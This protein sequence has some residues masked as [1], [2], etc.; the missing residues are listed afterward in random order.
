MS[1]SL[2]APIAKDKTFFFA[3]ADY[4]RQDRTTQL[5]NTLP[6]FVLDNGSLEYVGKYR[7]A[8]VDARV[9]H[10]LSPSQ[11][12]MFRGNFDRMFDTNPNDTVIGTTAPT[13][14]RKYTRRG[15]SA[16]AGHTAVVSPT[17][18]NEA[19]FGF[20]NGDPVTLWEAVRSS[21]IYQRTAGAA[22]FR[23]GASQFSDLYSRQA[24]LSD[25]LSWSRGRHYVRMGGSLARHLTGGIGNEPG[26][27]LLGTFT[28]VGTGAS[29]TLPFDQLTLADVQ[30]YTQPFSFGAPKSYI[31]NQWLGLLFVQDKFRPRNDLTLDLGFRYD[32]QTLTDATGN[33]VPRVGFGWHPNGDSRLSVH[34][35]YGMYYTQIRT[36]SV[37]GALM[38][39][40]DGF[41]T[42]TA[43][44]GQPGFP[45]CLTGTCLPVS[46][47]SSASSAPAAC[48]PS[49]RS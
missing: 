31:L 19:R 48:S 44:P 11:T 23:I 30:N 13:A 27:T 25:T 21:T 16:L 7:Q 33:I 38:N 2:G 46:F 4:T 26:Q 39:G 45:T 9:D 20:T 37:A 24:Q 47:G 35:G 5:S 40:L 36:N 18:L 34:G 22:P 1:G 42:Y 17:L 32:R 29:A 49:T 10:K 3:A 6:S 43:F 8:L 15:W 14:A 12:L 28:F 41:S